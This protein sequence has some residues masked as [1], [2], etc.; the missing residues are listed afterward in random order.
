MFFR[1][2]ARASTLFSAL[3]GAAA[4]RAARPPRT[5]APR[6]SPATRS[7]ANFEGTLLRI[8]LKQQNVIV[9]GPPDHRHRR[10]HYRRQHPASTLVGVDPFVVPPANNS[11]CLQIED[12]GF[13]PADNGPV[14]GPAHRD[15]RAARVHDADRADR[16]RPG[17][18]VN[19][20][21][22]LPRARIRTR[23]RSR[24]RVRDRTIADTDG[25][26]G[27]NVA[28]RRLRFDRPDPGTSSP[29]CGSISTTT[30]R[31]PRRAPRRR[32][33]VNLGP[34]RTRL[35]LSVT[36][37]R[38]DRQV[39]FGTTTVLITVNAPAIPTANAG[40]DRNI[41]DSDGEPG[42]SVMLDGSARRDT[43]GT[44]A[45]FEWSASIGVDET[46]AA[47]HGPD[48]DRHGC[49]TARTTSSCS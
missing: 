45:S 14:D 15:Q 42:E 12:E 7:G 32:P 28:A 16:T 35:T 48:A 5:P 43:D 34:A 39:G 30:S 2:L 38:G 3:V 6:C 8:N 49:P 4:R 19:T 37:T 21:A 31:S 22:D 33:T 46:E 29:I 27:E 17:P 47:R 11:V 41:P 10:H 44:I 9:G 18:V 40:P 20:P 13:D 25:Q 1:S 24:T 23:P 36:T 26:A